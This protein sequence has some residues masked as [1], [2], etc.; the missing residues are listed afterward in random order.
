VEKFIAVMKIVDKLD[1]EALLILRAAIAAGTI[2]ASLRPY[3]VEL[4]KVLNF[5]Q[6]IEELLAS[7]GLLKPTPAPT[8]TAVGGGTVPNPNA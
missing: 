2:P 8:P 7:F 1:D 3:A 4:E 5:F 6:K